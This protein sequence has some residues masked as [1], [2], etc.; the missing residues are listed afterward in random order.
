MTLSEL[1]K[2]KYVFKI[3]SNEIEK[4]DVF[5]AYGKGHNYVNDAFRKGA[6]FAVIDTEGEY[7]GKTIKLNNT[8]LDFLNESA[9]VLKTKMTIAITG[10]NGK[11]TT[12]ECLF[13]LLSPYIK[14]FKTQK[15]KNTE[16]GIP[17]SIFNEYN[18]EE[19]AILEMGLRKPGDL[20]LLSKVYKPDVA[21]ITNIGSSH[22]EF[23]KN[24]QM[25]SIE[26]MKV[27][28]SM[29]KGLLIINGDQNLKDIA[30]KT[31]NI[32]TFGKK[33]SNDGHLKEFFYIKNTTKVFY[34]VFGKELMLTLNGT[35][36]EGHL[37]DLLSAILFTV[38]IK[39][40]LD[41]TILSQITI[42]ESRF[43][44]HKMKEKTI[45]DDSYN[46]SYESFLNGFKTIERLQGKKIL[47]MGEVLESGDKKINEKILKETK[48]IFDEVYFFDSENKFS[49]LNVQKIKSFEEL[50]KLL[51][52][53]KGIIYIKA[54]NGTGINS[55]L[56]E[57]FNK[58][59]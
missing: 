58:N 27:T 35:W 20:E 54:S 38:F 4:N 40:P 5:V 36:T 50:E 31:L 56:K 32:L 12:K 19:V 6:S 28:S 41:P 2:A 14:T 18:D 22:M 29:D 49:T 8:T 42:P 21:F 23:F 55:F 48:D 43:F 24:K 45:I 9:K 57:Y 15:N 1:K 37:L 3:N 52:T 30:P 26:K 39:V 59:L 10:S 53:K 17:L 44:I 25:L 13:A 47:I 46:A 33:E 7:I 16:I 34:S 11:T 51:N